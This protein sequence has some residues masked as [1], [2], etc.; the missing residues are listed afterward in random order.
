MTTFQPVSNDPDVK[1][2]CDEARITALRNQIGSALPLIVECNLLR[3]ILGFWTKKQVLSEFLPQEDYSVVLSDHSKVDKALLSWARST[4]G[5]RLENLYLAEKHHLDRVTCSL[6]RV[7]DQYLAFELFH[8]LKA[9]ESSFD[10]L[11]W[12]FGE[13]QE[14]RQ[15][16]LFKNQRIQAIPEA[17][18]PIIRKMKKG[19][20][21][22]PHKFSEW[23]G[24]IR[25]DDFSP[26][27]F[28]EETKN[29]LLKAELNK[30]LSKV[31][32]ELESH[33]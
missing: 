1:L 20:V 33:L 8:R 32:G 26:A 16:G 19:S 9:E 21:S 4:W 3:N 27:Q 28:D 31:V 11:S 5:H 30:W 13:G 29:L 24:I 2:W 23:Y 7:K 12:K 6:L 14:R 10:E 25:L 17:L 22:K 15:G 18:H